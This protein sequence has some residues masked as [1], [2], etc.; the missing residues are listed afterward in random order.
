MN[1]EELLQKWGEENKQKI[2][3]G[4]GHVFLIDVMGDDEAVE[5]AARLSYQKGTRR[6]SDTRNLLRY[7]FRKQHATPFEAAVIKLDMKIPIFVARQLVRHRTQ[8]LSELSARYSILPDEWYTPPA[9]QICFQDDKNK[10]GRSGAF[11]L[12]EANQ[13]RD[14]MTD[15]AADAFATY[16]QFLE[17]GMARE[18]ARMGLPLSTY[19]RWNTTLSLRNLLH[20]L[21]LRLDPHAQWEARQVAEAV[22]QIVQD[23]VPLTAEAFVD[24]QLEAETFSRMDLAMLRD[25]VADWKSI[26]DDLC[27]SEHRDP[28]AHLDCLI[29]EM[30]ERHGVDNMRERK[31]LLDKLGLSS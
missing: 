27:A 5:A 2:L 16:H 10:Q 28:K 18:T 26:Q 1:R 25:I 19:T 7:M 31:E 4:Q 13:L 12:D 3:D 14:Q 22:W 30:F 15:E 11:P 29:S 20:M 23:W 17:A 24:Y 9:E 21:G 8:A 6:T